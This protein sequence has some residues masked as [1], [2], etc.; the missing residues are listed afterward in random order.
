[1]LSWG[2]R[3]VWRGDGRH[4]QTLWGRILVDIHVSKLGDRG[5]LLGQLLMQCQLSSSASD[6]GQDEE[7]HE[8]DDEGDDDG[9]PRVVVV[10]LST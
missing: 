10:G 1:M 3:G 8:D 9:A 2:R 5:G 6:A 4:G 7:D